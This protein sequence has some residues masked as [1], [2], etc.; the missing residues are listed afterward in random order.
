M[1]PK[2]SLLRLK[3]PTICSYPE[4]GDHSSNRSYFNETTYLF[5]Y[6]LFDDDIIGVDCIVL[7]D[8][9]LSG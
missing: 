7:N 4:P 3:E 2:S 5:I 6:I 1:E 9:L 8:R